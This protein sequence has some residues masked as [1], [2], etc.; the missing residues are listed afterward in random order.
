M[1]FVFKILYFLEAHCLLFCS[2]I[3]KLLLPGQCGDDEE[4]IDRLVAPSSESYVRNS[5]PQEEPCEVC[6][7]VATCNW[8]GSCPLSDRGLEVLVL[9]V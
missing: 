4:G 6:R 7:S 3:R 5:T 1:K 2:D 9:G 8:S